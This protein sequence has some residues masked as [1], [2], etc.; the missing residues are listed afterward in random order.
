LTTRTS[1]HID[2]V[3]TVD[4]EEEEFE[5]KNDEVWGW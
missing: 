3:G 2:F 5:L 4:G 1:M